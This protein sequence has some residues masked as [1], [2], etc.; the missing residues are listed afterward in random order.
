MASQSYQL[1]VNSGPNI[2]KVYPLTQSEIVIGRDP[3]SDIVINDAEVSRKHARLLL[4]AG[5][6]VLEDLGST[7][8][9]YVGGQKL[10]GPHT[11]RAGE[12]IMFGENIALVF[13]SPQFD[14]DATVIGAQPVSAPP[15]QAPSAEPSTP[16]PP[17]YQ[18]PPAQPVQAAPQ[19]TP[20]YSEQIPSSFSTPAEAPAVKP[21]SGSR[22]WLFAGCG[23][24]VL[25]AIGIAGILFVVDYL[26]L[27]CQ[28]FGFIIPG[29]Q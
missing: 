15:Q 24:V 16:P 25:A 9:T 28:L 26:N 14:P 29:C 5:S 1:V 7:N 19:K 18:A 6:Y 8:G 21:K 12:L 4:Q 3:T 10:M 20:V 27:W 23:C 11:L 17:V 22:L 2:G 13:Q